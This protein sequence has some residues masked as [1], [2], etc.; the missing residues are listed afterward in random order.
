MI[1]FAICT[2][3]QSLLVK[4][5]CLMSSCIRAVPVNSDEKENIYIILTML[6]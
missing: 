2:L 4:F 6:V 1:K 5:A 3:K